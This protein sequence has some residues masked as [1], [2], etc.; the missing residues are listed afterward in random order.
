MATSNL[1]QSSSL[2]IAASV[3]GTIF[4]GFGI[5][6]SLQPSSSI[7]FFELDAP[8]SASDQKIADALT[9]LYAVRD[10]FMGVSIYA[11][12]YFGNR[13]SLGWILIAAS[14]VAYADGFIVKTQIG[15]GEWNHWGYA[16]ML[17]VVGSLLLGA[18]DRA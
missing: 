16:P 5:K 15:K 17:T 2:R 4:L 6:F 9:L 8:T 7:P 14:G 1:S 12:T 3:I 18:L 10:I 13:K 11:A